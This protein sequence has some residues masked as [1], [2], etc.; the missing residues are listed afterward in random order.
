MQYAQLQA[1]A[2]AP[3]DMPD[4]DA[5]LVAFPAL[6]LAKTTPQDP[7]YHGEGDVWTHTKMVMEA[8]LALPQYQAADRADQEVVFLA[9][10]LHDV[11]KHSTTV[12]DPVTGAIGQ[13]GHS[14]KGA[15]DARIALWDAGVPFAV[16]EAVCRLIAVHQVPFFALEGS[17]RGKTPEFIVRELSWQVDIPLLAML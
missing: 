1:L 7:R 12:I 11:A 16:R 9:A 2:P 13:P 10:L 4:Y 14:R 15:I 6:E 17:R 5:C 3:G 8:L